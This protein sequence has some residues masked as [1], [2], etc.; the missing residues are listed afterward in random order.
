MP[1]PLALLALAGL[2]I[3]VAAKSAGGKGPAPAPEPVPGALRFVN[4]MLAD[5]GIPADTLAMVNAALTTEPDPPGPGGYQI[6]VN[7]I[8]QNAT[9]L[10]QNYPLAAGALWA[11]WRALRAYAL[12]QGWREPDSL[13]GE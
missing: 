11:R 10:Q 7:A 5:S 6:L 3:F 4:G 9:L 1:A 2:G 13:D 8:T 12:E